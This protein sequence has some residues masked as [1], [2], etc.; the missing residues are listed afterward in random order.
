MVLVV[1]LHIVARLGSVHSTGNGFRCENRPAVDVFCAPCFCGSGFFSFHLC[2]T[3]CRLSFLCVWCSL[4]EA[5]NWVDHDWGAAL[6]AV[7]CRQDSRSQLLLGVE[8]FAAVLLAA[9]F[10]HIEESHFARSAQ[11]FILLEDRLWVL[12]E[13]LGVQL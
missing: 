12:Q 5:S 4:A 3:F 1:A 2:F 8:W 9:H 11:K 10:V 6:G 13:V 7:M